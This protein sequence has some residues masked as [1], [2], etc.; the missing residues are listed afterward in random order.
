MGGTLLARLSL[1]PAGNARWHSSRG[2]RPKAR[3]RRS[4][5][6]A[7]ANAR[8]RRF[9]AAAANA[10]WRDSPCRRHECPVTQPSLAQARTPGDVD[11]PCAAANTRCAG[12]APAGYECTVTSKPSLFCKKYHQPICWSRQELPADFSRKIGRPAMAQRLRQIHPA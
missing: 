7:G 12:L 3:R 10:R 2:V 4:P 5:P 8:W 1:A 6:S 11:L 9:P